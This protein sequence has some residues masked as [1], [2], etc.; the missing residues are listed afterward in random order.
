MRINP[1]TLR[2]IILKM[3][4]QKKSGHIG[5]SFSI[6]D[7]ISKIFSE[8]GDRILTGE[9]VLIISKGHAVP[10]LYAVLNMVGAISDEELET[11][12]EIDS[13]LEGH[14]VVN[15]LP[16][17]GATTG[18][19]GQGLSIAIGR[20]LAKEKLGKNGT[21]SCII[22]DGELQEGQIW[23][24]LLFAN[25]YKP[26]N[27]NIYIDWNNSQNNGELLFNFNTQASAIDSIMKDFIF[28]RVYYFNDPEKIE[29]N[30]LNKKE[31]NIVIIKN[32]KGFG[33][34]KEFEGENSHSFIPN[35]EEYNII[36][37]YIEKNESEY[38]NG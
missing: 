9:D 30:N 6:V 5:P 16:L 27:L 13:R 1:W 22:G 35:E 14:P 37:K 31:P 38:N 33:L 4:Y 24:A 12:R 17:V 23:E 8:S 25:K 11:F 36:L 18:S 32:K 19:L 2:K 29:L 15:K 3:I 10:A 26:K 20:A 7:L 28:N 21:V 34:P